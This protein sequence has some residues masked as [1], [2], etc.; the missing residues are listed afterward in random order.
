MSDIWLRLVM[1][2]LAAHL[3]GGCASERLSPETCRQ[4]RQ[5]SKPISRSSFCSAAV[6]AVL[7]FGG[8]THAA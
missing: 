5:R 8:G 1:V 7:D 2:L 6:P 4:E 3:L